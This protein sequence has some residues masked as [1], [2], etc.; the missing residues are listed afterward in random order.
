MIIRTELFRQLRAQ[1]EQHRADVVIFDPMVELHTAPENDNA[2]MRVVTAELRTLARELRIAVLL[3]HHAPKG[4]ITPG[5]I[6]ALR[7]AGAIGGAVRFGYTVVRMNEDE[8]KECKIPDRLRGFYFRADKAKGSYSPPI[9][10]A[11]WFRKVGYNIDGEEVGTIRTWRPE[12]AKEAT[13]ADIE[14]L[15]A[16]IAK[17]CPTGKPWSPQRRDSPRSIRTPFQRFG[18]IANEAESRAMDALKTHGVEIVCYR[19]G[20]RNTPQGLRFEGKPDAL[21]CDEHDA[22]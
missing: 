8:A 11:E 18:F 13:D 5:D 7:G 21:W 1:V 2:L 12:E 9:S 19:D 14:A 17:G 6:S 16:E 22:E 20:N 10:E 15:V 4:T 3:L